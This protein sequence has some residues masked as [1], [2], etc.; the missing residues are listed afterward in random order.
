MSP[1]CRPPMIFPCPCTEL[2]RAVTYTEHTQLYQNAL[3]FMYIRATTWRAEGGDHK[4]EES[5]R[6]RVRCTIFR[7][8]R[9][10]EY[11]AAVAAGWGAPIKTTRD[12]QNR[13]ALNSNLWNL[14]ITFC[15]EY[16]EVGYLSHD[17]HILKCVTK[18]QNPYI[19]LAGV[20]RQHHIMS[21][22][23]PIWLTHRNLTH[24]QEPPRNRN[25]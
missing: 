13:G 19:K 12:K 10:G 1:P 9:V 22:V 14:G 23:Q 2:M 17:L 7:Y 6:E 18:A 11:I 20:H 25:L 4:E 24:E 3:H 8:P 15:I 5:D 16:S 21:L